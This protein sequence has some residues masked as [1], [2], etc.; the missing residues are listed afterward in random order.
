[1][2][3]DHTLASITHTHTQTPAERYCWVSLDSVYLVEVSEADTVNWFFRPVKGDGH[4]HQTDYGG[5]IRGHA[6][7]TL[8]KHEDNRCM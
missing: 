6:G 1:M 8:L 3:H 4:R 2:S 5:D 7:P